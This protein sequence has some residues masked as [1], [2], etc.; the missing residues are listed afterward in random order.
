M[1]SKILAFF[2]VSVAILIVGVWVFANYNDLF[3]TNS[4]NRND[5][6]KTGEINSFEECVE[7][8]Q[9]VMESY[10]R[11]CATSDGRT[12]VE[13]IVI[14]P[15]YENADA[16]MI[17]IFTPVPGGKVGKEF[18]VEGKARGNWFFEASFPIEV[19]GSGGNQIGAGIAT[20]TGDWMTTE[21]VEFKSDLID[22][23]S[24]Y[25]GPATL[26]L[27]K[28]NPSDLRENDASVSLPIVV[29]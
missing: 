3:S 2:F 4:T 6:D 11:Q 12:F 26:I 25:T 5:D 27:R 14:E 8:G 29:Q 7:S 21:F 10:P 17:E 19:I 13:V 16:D 18:M 23:P 28:D 20:A 9:P 1:S 22:L 15:T 24:A